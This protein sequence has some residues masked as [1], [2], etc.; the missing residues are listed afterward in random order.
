MSS[1]KRTC[2]CVSVCKGTLRVTGKYAVVWP[3]WTNDLSPVT[4]VGLDRYSCLSGSLPLLSLNTCVILCFFLR[5]INTVCQSVSQRN[6]AAGYPQ[7]GEW[8]W[9]TYT[10]QWPGLLK[11]RKCAAD[12]LAAAIC[13][14]LGTNSS[15]TAL[16][17][18]TT[19][20]V[21]HRT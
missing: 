13:L 19:A 7:R 18:S 1:C 20:I 8:H 11:V 14:S 3:V 17:N 4:G 6:L 5:R 15:R 10:D 21:W 2:P 16:N 12:R 9:R